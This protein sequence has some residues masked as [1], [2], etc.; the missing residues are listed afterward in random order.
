MRD[1]YNVLQLPPEVRNEAVIS[2]IESA[3]MNQS[4]FSSLPERIE[5]YEVTFEEDDQ[6]QAVP[7]QIPGLGAAQR[8]IEQDRARKDSSSSKR[9]HGGDSSKRKHT[10]SK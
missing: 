7:Q 2:L 5:K 6:S 10:S 1:K 8:L 3:R 9:S 4:R